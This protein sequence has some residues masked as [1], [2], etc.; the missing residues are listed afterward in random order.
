MV[1]YNRDDVKTFA[2]PVKKVS[3][4]VQNSYVPEAYYIREYKMRR[5][6]GRILALSW[7][8]CWYLAGVE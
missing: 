8:L 2:Y 7:Q 5:K 1:M 4:Q 3:V 6:I